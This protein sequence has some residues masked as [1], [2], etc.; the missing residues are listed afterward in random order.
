[1]ISAVNQNNNTNFGQVNLV[2]VSKKAFKNPENMKACKRDFI[3][4]I[5]K[6]NGDKI[7]GTKIGHY[8]NQI[9]FLLTNKKHDSIIHMEGYRMNLIMAAAS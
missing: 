9:L 4:Q 6:I 1:M 3:I 2:R 5:D 7:G 8:I